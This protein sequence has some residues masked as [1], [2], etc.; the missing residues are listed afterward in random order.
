MGARGLFC[1]STWRRTLVALSV[2]LALAIP[3]SAA[4]A[5]GAHEFNARLSLT[6]SCSVFPTDEVPDP[7]VCPMPPGVPGV[8]H[9]LSP[10]S[11]PRRLA[12]D[13]YGDMFVD[14]FGTK[15]N[16]ELGRIDVFDSSGFFTTEVKVPTGALNIAVDDKGNLYVIN[17][18]N[19][20]LRYPPSVYEPTSHDIAYGTSPATVEAKNGAFTVDLAVSPLDEH[21]LVFYGNEI[22]EFGSAAEG[23]PKIGSFGEGILHN[24]GGPGLAI[25]ASKK[26][27]YAGDI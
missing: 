24:P 5:E 18:K 12:T 23:N 16:G 26:R 6:G 9:P 1:R 4:S 8:D 2:G 11:N 15:E 22:V 27:L 7:G 19:E 20:L 3:A 14:S 10:F 13:S 21:V 17:E 25:D